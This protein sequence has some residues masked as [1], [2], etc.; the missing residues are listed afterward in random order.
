VREGRKD[1]D[2][3]KVNNPLAQPS[4]RTMSQAKPWNPKESA[5]LASQTPLETL[6]ERDPNNPE[7]LPQSVE[8]ALE[9]DE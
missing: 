7:W 3:R 1:L 5:H 4:R 6:S 2:Y 8:E 9:S